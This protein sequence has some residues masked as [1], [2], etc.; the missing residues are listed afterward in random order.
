MQDQGCVVHAAMPVRKIEKT[1]SLLLPWSVRSFSVAQ[2]LDAVEGGS[3]G[4]QEMAC[5]IYKLHKHYELKHGEKRQVTL[6]IL[7]CQIEIVLKDSKGF[8][9]STQSV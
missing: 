6:V 3:F 1:L 5:S 2:M 7:F 9:C 4:P 8:V